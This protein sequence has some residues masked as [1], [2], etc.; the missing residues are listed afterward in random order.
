MTSVRAVFLLVAGLLGGCGGEMVT[1]TASS[2]PPAQTKAVSNLTAFM[3]DS[4]TQFWNIPAFDP[5][6]NIN[7]GVVDQ[8]SVDMLA[9]FQ[10]DVIASDPG[11]V[12]ILA[13]INDFFDFGPAKANTDSIKAMAAM[14][15]AA[16]IKVILCSVMP[17]DYTIEPQSFTQ[18]DVQAFNDQLIEIART[19]GYLYADYYDQ[20]LNPDGSINLSL[21]NDGLHPTDAGYALMWKVLAPLLAED[22]P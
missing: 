3:G 7:F 19:N 8:T 15:Q 6:P 17:S 22:Q 10:T 21:F 9:R 5:N 20:F 4:I 13:G 11:V 16:G 1:V 12:V 2:A 14:A 18:A